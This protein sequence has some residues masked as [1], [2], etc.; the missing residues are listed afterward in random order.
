MSL[1]STPL[2]T[3]KT[4]TYPLHVNRLQG[5]GILP[6]SRVAAGHFGHWQVGALEHEQCSNSPFPPPPVQHTPQSH[7]VS[8]TNRIYPRGTVHTL[9]AHGLRLP[10]EF[11]HGFCLQLPLVSFPL[12][13]HDAAA[14]RLLKSATADGRVAC[15]CLVE[16]KLVARS[17]DGARCVRPVAA[18]R[19][20]SW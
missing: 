13:F 16:T 10:F 2:K 18:R 4:A 8:Y 14:T 5:C 7:Y 9:I 1:R 12:R 15:K 17:L 6:H 11:V 19:V 3:P 20:P